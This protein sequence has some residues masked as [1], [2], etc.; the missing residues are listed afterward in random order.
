ML[1]NEVVHLTW[2]SGG[3]DHRPRGLIDCR[4]VAAT[5]V[6]GESSPWRGVHK[7]GGG[8]AGVAG[9]WRGAVR[10]GDAGCGGR[11]TAMVGSVTRPGSAGGSVGRCH[12]VAGEG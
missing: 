3:L 2:R 9:V 10:V 1:R 12:D 8:H 7:A 5:D 4:E 11:A 6:A